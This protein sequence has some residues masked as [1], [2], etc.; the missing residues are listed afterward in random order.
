VLSPTVPIGLIESDV[1]GTP[2]EHWSSPDAL[3]ACEGPRPWDMPPGTVDSVLWNAM[4]VGLLRTTISGVAWYQGENNAAEPRRYSCSFP[5]MIEDWRAKW[6][7]LTDNATAR[8]FPF[9]WAQL[10]S[11]GTGR[12]DYTNRTFN[13]LHPP[14]NC[15]RG[16]APACSSECLGR[17][18]EWGDYG[19]GFTGLRYAQS[20]ALRVRN[21]FQAVIIDTPVASGSIHSPFKQPVGRRLARGALAVA[22]GRKELHA[23]DPVATGAVLRAGAVEISVGGLGRGGLMAA[24]GARGFEVLGN[25]S[26]PTLCW[27]SSPISAAS[28]DAVTL[29]ALPAQPQAVRYLWYIDAVGVHPFRAPIYTKALP[30]PGAPGIK[31]GNGELLPLGPFLLPL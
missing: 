10:N 9:G 4:V 17:Y 29:S 3:R 25:C 16:C 24:I 8:Q 19:N 15:G 26:G 12:Q 30:L 7:A 5:A 2:D 13:P 22:Y 23:A 18:H 27:M 31:Y 20:A 1:G 21:T 11:D 6:H 28:A 14:A